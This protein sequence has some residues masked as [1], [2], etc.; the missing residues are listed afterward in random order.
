[1]ATTRTRDDDGRPVGPATRDSAAAGEDAVIPVLAEELAV[2]KRRVET[3]AGVRVSK[4]VETREQV[5][6]VPLVKEDVDVQRVAINA[7]IDAPPA[8]RY[9]GDVMVIPIIEEVVVV[10]KRLMLKEEIRITRRQSELREP[11]R[12]TLRREHAEV[13]RIENPGS[14][15]HDAERRAA[16]ADACQDTGVPAAEDDLLERKRKQHENLRRDLS[17]S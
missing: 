14:Q 16:G 5:V 15:A 13:G 2:G 3:E 12:V 9:E 4:T 6:D 8:V 11:Q 17:N 1:V 10:E 7:P